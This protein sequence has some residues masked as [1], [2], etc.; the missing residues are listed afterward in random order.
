MPA[1]SEPR[2]V[3]VAAP[4]ALLATVSAVGL[5]VLASDPV[6][7]DVVAEHRDQRPR[8]STAPTTRA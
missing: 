8:A 4:L 1:A 5:G 2:A 3:T 6:V 7:D